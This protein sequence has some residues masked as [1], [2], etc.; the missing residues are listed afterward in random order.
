VKA[1][2]VVAPAPAVSVA[3]LGFT[4]GQ[5]ACFRAFAKNTFAFESVA[6][7]VVA[8]AFPA[9]TPNPPVL[10]ASITV[11]YDIQL[12]SNG[13]ILLGRVVGEM[14]LGTPC[15]DNDLQTNRGVYYPVNRADVTITRHPR[16]RL[17]VTQCA[18]E[19]ANG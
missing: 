8:K 17:I 15:V 4:D 7:N 3:I 11:A 16:S 18:W 1:G 5:V 2:E 14:P 9:P 13:D 12:K 6:S 19:N 10:G